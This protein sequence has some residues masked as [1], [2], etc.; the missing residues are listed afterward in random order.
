MDKYPILRP[1]LRLF[2]S[3]KAIALFIPALIS[4]GLDISPE[5]QAW[6]FVIAAG[7]YALT[8]AYEDG[9]EKSNGKGKI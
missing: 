2:F 6:V 9:M 5:L 8:T 7:L 4:L 1:L 3:S